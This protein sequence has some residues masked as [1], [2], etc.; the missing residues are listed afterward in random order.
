MCQI[1]KPLGNPFLLNTQFLNR[2]KCTI[3]LGNR[4]I[5]QINRFSCANILIS[6]LRTS[7][8]SSEEV[9]CHFSKKFNQLLTK[10]TGFFRKSQ[11]GCADV[12]SRNSSRRRLMATLVS[13]DQD[14]SLLCYRDMPSIRQVAAFLQLF[15]RISIGAFSPGWRTSR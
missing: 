4:S 8:A 7:D 11:S 1:F 2:R 14:F 15:A 3:L 5:R 9:Q 10:Q 6:I 12:P 13:A